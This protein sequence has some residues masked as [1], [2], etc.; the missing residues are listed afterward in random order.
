MT[1]SKIYDGTSSSSPI[2]ASLSGNS[3][4]APVRSTS[5]HLFVK[6]T[7]DAS[8][9]FDGFTANYNTIA[10]SSIARCSTSTSAILTQPEGQFGCNGYDNSVDSSWAITTTSGSRVTLTFAA[11][12]TESYYDYVKIYDGTN[13]H[14]TLLGT[15]SGT[16]PPALP[17]QSSSNSVFVTF[18]SDGSVSSSYTGWTIGYV[19]YGSF[20]SSCNANGNYQLSTSSGGFGCDGYANAITISWTISSFGPI[21]LEFDRFDTEQNYDVVYIFDG[22]SNNSPSLAHFS[23]TTTTPVT[24]T[25]NNMF[26]KFTSDSSITR[27]GFSALYSTWV[28]I[29]IH[30]LDLVETPKEITAN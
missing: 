13:S 20:G 16:T 17:I 14:A 2:L 25:G 22:T 3:L 19:S 10:V 27:S 18:H 6:F 28:N 29:D 15:Y 9:S 11:L 7:S 23:G 1:L 24:S 12:D 26:I 30:P 5:N 4:P 21:H 8:V